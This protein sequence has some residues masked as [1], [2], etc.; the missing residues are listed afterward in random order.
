VLFRLP[1]C[2]GCAQQYSGGTA[3]DLNVLT[4]QYLYDNT[5]MDEAEVY[6]K[7]VFY[8]SILKDTNDQSQAKKLTWLSYLGISSSPA[9]L[10]KF[11]TDWACANGFVSI[12]VSLK[13]RE[14]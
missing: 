9:G 14:T 4:E 13:H 8:T 5:L 6:N 11:A 3:V 2:L 1:S 12:W 7:C 10:S